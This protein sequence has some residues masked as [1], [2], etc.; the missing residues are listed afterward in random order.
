M[1]RKE[2][3]LIIAGWP[4]NKYIYLPKCILFVK[5]RIGI[6]TRVLQLW[7]GVLLSI[8]SKDLS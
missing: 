8:L 4:Q 2:Q 3:D 1:H 7:P 5:S 6:T